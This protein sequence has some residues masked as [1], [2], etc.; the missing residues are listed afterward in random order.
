MKKGKIR[1][2][3]GTILI[4]LQLL[5]M[6]GNPGGLSMLPYAFTSVYAFS[7]CLG[8]FCFGIIGIILLSSGLSAR[9]K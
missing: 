5:G 8:Y 1:I 9:N 4:V 3:L 2:V 6:I 7:Y